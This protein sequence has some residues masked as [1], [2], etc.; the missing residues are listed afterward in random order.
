M[1]SKKK[2]IVII[3]ILGSLSVPEFKNVA[4]NIKFAKPQAIQTFK[5]TRVETLIDISPIKPAI[6]IYPNES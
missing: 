6:E 1:S 5:M 3:L 2:V 4:N